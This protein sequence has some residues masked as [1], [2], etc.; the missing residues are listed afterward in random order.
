MDSGHTRGY[1]QVEDESMEA[2]DEKNNN[3][4]HMDLFFCN[5]FSIFFNDMQRSH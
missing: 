1:T 3:E 2:D 5:R 4:E